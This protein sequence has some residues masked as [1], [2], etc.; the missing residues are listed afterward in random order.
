MSSLKHFLPAKGRKE[1]LR[2]QGRE[3]FDNPLL[4]LRYSG[5]H[6]K[7]GKRPLELRV[8]ASRQSARKSESWSHKHNKLNFAN[9]L[10][11]LRS[12]FSPKVSRHEHKLADTL[13]SILRNLVELS[14][15]WIP[16]PQKL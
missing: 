11:E 2:F 16:D 6:A 14:C 12:T 13:I 7:T 9:S 1:N 15:T 4:T 3:G 8:I 5:P 10:N